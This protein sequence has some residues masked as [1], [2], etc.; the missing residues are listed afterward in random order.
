MTSPSNKVA[1]IGHSWRQTVAA[2]SLGKE[3]SQ[4]IS[5]LGDLSFLFPL[6]IWPGLD[7]KLPPSDF[8]S[9]HLPPPCLG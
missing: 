6:P 5:G 7:G 9:I 3:N 8:E 2:V 1:C 4:V